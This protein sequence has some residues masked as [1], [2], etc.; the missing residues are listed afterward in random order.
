[1]VTLHTNFGDIKIKLD[2]DKAPVTAENFLNYCKDGF[3]NNTIFHRVIDGFMIQGGGMES[4]M[5]EKA[6]KAPIQNEANNR[7]SNKRGTIAMARTSDPHS[8]QE[9]GYAVFGEVVEGMD[10]VDKIKKVKTGNKGFHQDV[11]TEDVVITSV[12]VE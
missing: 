6:T 1:M 8:V 3:Y 7:L 2:F 9:W 12:S 4:G 5:R 10:V 11:P